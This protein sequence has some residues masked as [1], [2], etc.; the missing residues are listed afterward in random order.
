M[1]F[2]EI[3]QLENVP[4]VA[5]LRKVWDQVPEFARR[6]VIRAMQSER[7]RLSLL[8]K[9]G[10]RSK[11][12]FISVSDGGPVA[13][14]AVMKLVADKGL[15]GDYYEFG[16]YR[17]YSFWTA[18]RSSL[19]CGL[20]GMRF[21]GFDSF[22]GLP[23]VE[24]NDRRAGIFIPGDYSCTK[25][26]VTN[27][28]TDHG[29][30]WSRAALIEGYFDASLTDDAKAQYGMGPAAVVMV[31]CDLYQSTVPVLTFLESLLQDGTIVLFDDWRCFGER[32]D[33]GEPRA[34]GEFLERNPD[35][36]AE[37][38]LEYPTYGKVFVLR[39][40]ISGGAGTG[41]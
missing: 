29:F 5:R 14:K 30:D 35:W 2:D 39:R 16:L 36:H 23:P 9:L 19:D 22:S 33:S 6:P 18:Q 28:L 11:S 8:D 40:A 25:E 32:P 26:V 10:I 1:A 37:P 34:F 3:P 4:R 7:L 17:G 31:D 15:L 27:Y 20:N 38:L 21:F 13:I 24:G 12:A 41:R